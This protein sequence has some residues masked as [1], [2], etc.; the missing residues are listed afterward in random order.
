MSWSAIERSDALLS[1][2]PGENWSFEKVCS[3]INK[4][5]SIDIYD[6]TVS[7]HFL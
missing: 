5:L 3:E 6:H 1:L 2:G 7:F 4:N